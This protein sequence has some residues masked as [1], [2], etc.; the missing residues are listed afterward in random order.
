MPDEVYTVLLLV[1]AEDHAS[2]QLQTM[3]GE[4]DKTGSSLSGMGGK[5]RDAE[6]EEDNLAK[7]SESM[8]ER[9]GGV[10]EKMGQQANNWGLPF[11][12]LLSETG[13]KMGG[14]E[15]KTTS[16]AGKLGTLGK[17]TTVG[18]AAGFIA[19]SAEALH[20]T[21]NYQK[22]EAALAS[23]ADISSA[24]ADK[25]GGAFV[26][27]G[28]G[29][30]QSAQE[31]IA[32]YT[33]VAAQLA[34]V[35]GGALNA[36]QALSVVKASTDLAEAAGGKLGGSLADVAKLMQ[37][38]GQTSNDAAGDADVLFNSSRLTGQSVD[39]FTSSVAKMKSQLGVTAPSISDTSAL[40]VDLTEHGETGRQ[41]MTAVST[42]L[43]G[44]LK[45]S[46]NT[47]AVTT[48]TDKLTKAQQAAAT[49]AQAVA[50]AQRN[51]GYTQETVAASGKDTVANQ[52]SLAKAHD[53]VVAAEQKQ[54]IAAQN[55]TQAQDEL[56]I[57][58]HASTNAA[59][60]MGIHV[61]DA[62]GKFVGMSSVIAQLQPI[63][64][65]HTQQQ[66]LTMLQTIGF[67]NA[68]KKMLETILAGPQAFDNI[69]AKIT[70]HG[71][72]EAGAEKATNTL[73]GQTEKLK[74]GVEDLG[75][76]YG[77]WLTPKLKEVERVGADVV[78][79][80]EKNKLVAEGLALVVGG[81]LTVAVATFAYQTAA[82]FVSSVGD[83]ISGVGKLK[84]KISGVGG[85]EGL[86]EEG[87]TAADAMDTA[88]QK[89]QA[90]AEALNEAA[91]NLQG[92][93][94]AVE[95]DVVAGSETASANLEAAGS[96]VE[97]DITAGGEAAEADMEAGGA[98]AESSE[99][100][101]GEAGGAGGGGIGA[102]AGAGV[103]GAV[104][105]V[106][107]GQKMVA[108][109]KGAAA[110]MMGPIKQVHDAGMASNSAS[111]IWADLQKVDQAG[112]QLAAAYNKM[113]IIGN[114]KARGQLSG[115]IKLAQQWADALNEH[116]QQVASSGMSPASGGSGGS[117]TSV[118]GYGMKMYAM[119]GVVTSD[120]I[121]M[122]HAPEV[123]L[124]L[125]NP[126]RMN[127]LL[128][129]VASYLPTSP[130]DTGGGGYAP[131]AGG[132]AR[133]SGTTIEQQNIYLLTEALDAQGVA[134]EVA[135]QV[136][137]V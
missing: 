136:K 55:V 133:S 82:K 104:I 6:N 125:D 135:W 47:K 9:V 68:N 37:A 44:L 64:K 79:W 4:L 83:M 117:A 130:G 124:P 1:E 99:A 19:A 58:A 59:E 109:W 48:A 132:S 73:S 78:L 121:A 45:T 103:M 119:G 85:E 22:S 77:E 35:Q 69:S 88:A 95:D 102:A 53:A 21:A 27:V 94:T 11:G 23:S 76:S 29:S 43:T 91:Q 118:P 116:Y 41:A 81:I 7:K 87:E 2:K 80:L 131:A 17:V 115:G 52:V 51:L 108:G 25:I 113:P 63:M 101:G 86:G 100:A 30:T 134:R 71:S 20:L 70:A 10:F 60:Q 28:S 38:Y 112:E 57:T 66:D 5:L 16:L 40:I 34:S 18:V 8:G 84:D 31:M 106:Q 42:S 128:G 54:S 127:E 49:A 122:L 137:K 110:G 96:A 74:A 46:D 56:Y 32:A 39:A 61:Y 3:R 90:A 62:T 50:N 98:A 123:V 24:A 26:K 111:T 107:Q 15:G 13:E 120:T 105:G 65:S 93:G 72:A 114:E 126:A 97:A 12:N 33:P 75:V 36:A 129:Q 67:G 89:L 14:V 92:A